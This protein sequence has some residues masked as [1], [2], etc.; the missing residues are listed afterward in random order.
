[1]SSI[2]ILKIYELETV[3]RI[4]LS[5]LYYNSLELGIS[6]M[7]QKLMLQFFSIRL[8]YRQACFVS[9][10]YDDQNNYSPTQGGTFKLQLYTLHCKIYY[11]KLHR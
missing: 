7:L 4:K 1:M 9:N 10:A 2:V 8:D 3:M 6:I 5:C 11:V